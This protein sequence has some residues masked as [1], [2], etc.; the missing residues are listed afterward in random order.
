MLQKYSVQEGVP[1]APDNSLFL[2]PAYIISLIKR[3]IL[4]FLVPFVLIF[5]V[6]AAIV[7]MMPPVYYSGGKILVE[8]QQNSFRSRPSHGIG[9][10]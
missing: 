4:Y 1:P 8:G 7:W 2:T 6:G 3:R 10:G 5:S 9:A